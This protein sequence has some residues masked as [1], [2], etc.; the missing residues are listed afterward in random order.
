MVP[1]F[2]S[3][4][5]WSCAVRPHNNAPEHFIA[6]PFACL[7]NPPPPCHSIGLAVVIITFIAASLIEVFE[8]DRA[9]FPR[10]VSLARRETALSFLDCQY[11]VLVTIAT[12]GY[13]VRWGRPVA[14]S[15]CA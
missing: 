13:G 11:F 15:L 3:L 6:T 7:H 4:D 2:H 12:I 10:H 8:N 9:S 14:T 5:A 1:L